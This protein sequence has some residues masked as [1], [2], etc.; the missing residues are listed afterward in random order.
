MEI[1]LHFAEGGVLKFKPKNDDYYKDYGFD[2]AMI[3]QL[4]QAGDYDEI[5]IAGTKYHVPWLYV[6]PNIEA[7]IKLEYTS[8]NPELDSLIV[9]KGSNSTVKFP[10]EGNNDSIPFRSFTTQNVKVKIETTIADA[11]FSIT[12]YAI[13]KGNIETKIGQLNIRSKVLSD[14]KKVRIIHVRRSDETEYTSFSEDQKTNLINTL[15][16]YYKQTFIRFELDNTTYQNTYTIAKTKNDKIDNLWND[17]YNPYPSKEDGAYHIFIC[18][19][20]NKNI[21]AGIGGLVANY[22]VLFNPNTVTPAHELGHNLGLQHTFPPEGNE[23]NKDGDPG[24]CRVSN[25]Y[26]EKSKTKNIMDYSGAPDL[27]KLFFKY[28]IEH[29]KDR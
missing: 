22:S 29:L 6:L 25:K 13:Q 1:T 27:R 19:Q 23:V 2:D 20:G 18:S 8:K 9:L 14:P 26:I 7:E 3:L 16:E 24:V 10:D 5:P 28:Q 4:Q 15:N 12:A 17:L 21:E 11:T